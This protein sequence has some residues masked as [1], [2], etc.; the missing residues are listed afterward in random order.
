MKINIVDSIMG[1]GKT[2]AAINKMKEDK[3]NK[4]IFITPFLKEVERIKKSCVD[5]SFVEP[6]NRGLGKLD[7]L[8]YLIGKDRNIASTHALFKAYNEETK[9]ILSAKEYVLILDEV[10][11]VIEHIPLHIDDIN[12]MLKNFAYVDDDDFVVWIDDGYNGT[13]FNEIKLMAKNRN[14]MLIK[15]TLLLWNFPISVFDLF[16]EVYVMSYMFDAQIQKYYYDMNNVEMVYYG[17]KNDNGYYRFADSTTTPDYVSTLKNNIIIC[18]R[19]KLNI[20]GDR[21]TAL[22]VSWFE[23]DKERRGKPLEKILKNNM[24]NYFNNINKS[25]S[26]MNMWT[27]FKDF[28][29]HLSGM[30]YTKGFVSVNARATNEYKE[31]DCLAYC[32]NIFLNPRLKNYFLN[33]GISVLEDEYALS[34]M[35]QWIWRSAIRDGKKINVYIPSSRMRNLLIDWLNKVSV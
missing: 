29:P 34:E 10:F 27:T 4:Y 1:S 5:R 13:K 30:G 6:E 2:T 32:A 3:N 9:E 16:K 31:R 8:N 26:K 19:E 21:R 22:S 15:D 23:R 24:I 11:N 33:K 18:D 35:I 7:N 12:I 25:P 28:K 14:L 17:V 20:V